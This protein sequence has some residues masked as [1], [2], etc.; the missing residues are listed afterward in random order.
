MGDARHGDKRVR[1]VV[2]MA[3]LHLGNVIH[4]ASD[5]VRSLGPC[6]AALVERGVVG[7]V[8]GQPEQIDDIAFDVARL[9][10]RDTIFY[11]AEN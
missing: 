6:R 5:P 1:E 3:A 11:T 2:R 7:V 9:K 10:V 4:H 8:V